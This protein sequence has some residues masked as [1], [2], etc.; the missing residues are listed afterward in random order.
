[1]KGYD[2]VR[3]GREALESE[4]FGLLTSSCSVFS[5]SLGDVCLS[6][7]LLLFIIN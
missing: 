7:G 6:H 5:L 4:T 2:Y 1:M 3:I